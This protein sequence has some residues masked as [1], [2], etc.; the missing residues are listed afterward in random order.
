MKLNI[1]AYTAPNQ[2]MPPFVSV[3]V[4]EDGR[5]MIT[6]RS[7]EADGGGCGQAEIPRTQ[8][9]DLIRGLQ[10]VEHRH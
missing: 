3:N 5:V 8:I 10:A 6:V 2:G 1:F 9:P 7:S 4:E